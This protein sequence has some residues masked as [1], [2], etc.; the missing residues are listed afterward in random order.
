M[1]LNKYLKPLGDSAKLSLAELPKTKISRDKLIKDD[2]N[3]LK[4]DVSTRQLEV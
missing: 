1:S 3:N 2:G 4:S